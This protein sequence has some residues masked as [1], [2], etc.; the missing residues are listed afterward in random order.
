M[1][2]RVAHALERRQL[3]RRLVLL[4][5]ERARER[6]GRLHQ[7]KVG[8]HVHPLLRR[9]RDGP[10]LRRAHAAL[11]AEEH[12]APEAARP[13]A[14]HEVLAVARLA[15]VH[16]HHRAHDERHALRA[17]ALGRPARLDR[18]TDRHVLEE[19]PHVPRARRLARRERV[20]REHHVH[21]VHRARAS[22]LR[23][24][25]ARRR[26]ARAGR[27]RTPRLPYRRRRASSPRCRG[28]PPSMKDRPCSGE[29]SRRQSPSGKGGTS[30]ER[31]W[32]HR[33]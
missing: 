19:P 11:A 25:V 33:R 9:R 16:D 8:A 31:L 15:M 13:R 6:V 14:P 23:T 2:A 20:A 24:L 1:R 18:S 3:D 27:L 30:S 10:F 32:H 7:R 28:G 5:G 21:R 12:P 4:D 26:A 29:V 22:Q 17:I